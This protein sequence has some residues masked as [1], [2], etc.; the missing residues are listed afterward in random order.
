MKIDS[1][2]VNAQR[3]YISSQKITSA[4]F[5]SEMGISP[6]CVVKW[7]RVGN[8]ITEQKWQQLFPKIKKYLPKDRIYIDDSG[9]ERYQSATEHVSGYVFEPKYVPAM[10]PAIKLRY[11]SEFDNVIESIAQFGKRLGAN[12]V[13]YHPKHPDHAGVM[14]IEIDNNLYYPVFPINTTLFV[15]T[16]GASISNGCLC[17]AKDIAGEVFIGHYCEMK[18][19]FS[20]TDVLTNKPLI[21]GEISAARNFIQ[22]IFPVLYYEV[23][24]F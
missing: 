4:E 18:R 17:V 5:A 23:V 22:W 11:I 7:S 24:T 10:V 8:G 19:Q 2:I 6:A 20:V 3:K 16:G 12:L 14:A 21:I 9:K 13:E 15:C 1:F